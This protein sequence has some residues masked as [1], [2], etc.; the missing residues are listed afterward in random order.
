MLQKT[1][2]S[3]EWGPLRGL[4]LVD[5]KLHVAILLQPK[6]VAVAFLIKNAFSITSSFGRH[7]WVLFC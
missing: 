6:I 2:I 5:I 7:D 1:I 3:L 4:M